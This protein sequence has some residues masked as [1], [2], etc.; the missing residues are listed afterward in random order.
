MGKLTQTLSPLMRIPFA[1]LGSR[2]FFLSGFL[3]CNYVWDYSLR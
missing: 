2:G 3:D 1:P